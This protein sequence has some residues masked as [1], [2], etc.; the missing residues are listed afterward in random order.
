MKKL[1]ATAI[2]AALIA[3]LGAAF[4]Q[5]SQQHQVEVR[6]PE[7]MMIRIVNAPSNAAVTDPAPV[8]FNLLGLNASNFE[9]EGAQTVTSS[10]G[11]TGSVWNQVRVFVNSVRSWSVNV[12]VEN[13]E[14][15]ANQPAFDWTNVSVLGYDLPAA[16]ASTPTTI[17]TSGT[18]R[19]TTGWENIGITPTS[20]S[21]RLDGTEAAGTYRANITYTISNP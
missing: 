10:L 20:F 17:F 13:V 3:S 9:P 5:T 7:V 15:P 1:L 11:T 2:V 4:A 21:L 16:G 18:A 6:I 8:V 14:Q 12:S 19:R